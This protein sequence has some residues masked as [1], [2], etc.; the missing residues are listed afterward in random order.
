[1]EQSVSLKEVVTLK[2]YAEQIIQI[3]EN[4]ESIQE[5][6]AETDY[7]KKMAKVHAYENIVAIVNIGR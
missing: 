2:H 6:D 7:T 4:C 3:I 5:D 1:M